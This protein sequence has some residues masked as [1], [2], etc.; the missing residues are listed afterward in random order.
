MRHGAGLIFFHML[1]VVWWFS[2]RCLHL[3]PGSRSHLFS[4]ILDYVVV[5]SEVFALTGCLRWVLCR[6]GVVKCL[7]VKEM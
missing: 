1:L 2:V 4:H 7:L 3:V 5:W 6:G